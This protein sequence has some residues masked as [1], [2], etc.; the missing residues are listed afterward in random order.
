MVDSSPGLIAVSHV[1]HRLLVPRHPPCALLYLPYKMLALAME[2]SRS[3]DAD[4]SGASTSRDGP[5]RRVPGF[6]RRNAPS[7]LHRVP[8]RERRFEGRCASVTCE[9]VTG[10]RPRNLTDLVDE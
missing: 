1:L 3:V 8:I 4:M 9:H 2:F 10:C 7:E 6:R 5:F